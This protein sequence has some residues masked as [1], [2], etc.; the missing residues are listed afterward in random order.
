MKKTVL[1]IAILML[2]MTSMG[3][4]HADR[5]S[6]THVG[7]GVMINPYWGPWYYPPPFYYPNYPP[8]IIERPDPPVYI[9]QAQPA[10]TANAQTNYW[11]YCQ[12]ANGYYP[13]VKECPG[14]WLKVSPRPSDSR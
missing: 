14:G 1:I 7:V 2:G 9:E 8:V 3:N 10:D 6:R 13:Y 11:Y 4:V 12:T 5:R